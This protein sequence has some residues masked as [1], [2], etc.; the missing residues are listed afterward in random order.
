VPDRHQGRNTR[1]FP[2]VAAMPGLDEK[3]LGQD[4]DQEDRDEDRADFVG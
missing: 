1:I 3:G 2:R 4:G